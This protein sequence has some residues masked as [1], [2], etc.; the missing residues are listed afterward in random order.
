MKPALI[1]LLS[2]AAFATANLREDPWI[3]EGLEKS[4]NKDHNN[5]ERRTREAVEVHEEPVR[6]KRCDTPQSDQLSPIASEYVRRPR[7]VHQYEVH[8]FH[9]E[10]SQPSVPYEEMLAASA[11]HYH[12]VYAAPGAKSG[13][14][15]N[16]D[17]SRSH[18]TLGVHAVP[19]QNPA[20]YVSAPGQLGPSHSPL[21]VVNPVHASNFASNVLPGA[22]SVP[23]ANG[24]S[25]VIVP[26]P[27]PQLSED[28]FP[29]AGHHHQ[30]QKHHGH[31]AHV[32]GG[33]HG[34]QGHHHSDH[35]A[36]TTKGFKTDQHVDKGGKGFKKDENHRK[37]YEEAAG[38]KTKHHDLAGHKGNHEEE[39]HGHRGSNFEE[40]K[41]HK[42][43]HK[44][45]GYHNK[46]HKDEFHKEH[47]FYDD[48]HKSGEHHRYGKFNAKHA[49]NESGK[50]KAHHINAG[51]DFVERG[52]KGYSNKG[53]V[54]ADH[55]GYNGK[56]GHEEHHENHSEY[57][58]KGG[59]EGGSHWGHAKRN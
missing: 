19:S 49:S 31:H 52:K 55:K 6:V 53:H 16:A 25:P 13:R 57:G 59:K 8:E 37:E 5:H 56:K 28:Q 9:E 30:Q 50:K 11:E 41:G 48:Y 34:H 21:S 32:Q 35:G 2:L 47:K 51:H 17:V 46:Y 1:W 45:K 36:K 38:K 18:N 54:D 22:A 23:S 44:T 40:K 10:A 12:K 29:A 14:Y 26:A 15:L 4:Y 43:G 42:K 3:E 39:A 33:G 20:Q 7:Q 27:Q 24:P 58:K